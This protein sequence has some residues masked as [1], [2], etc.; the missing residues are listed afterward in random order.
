MNELGGYQELV[1]TRGWLGNG[2]FLLALV[3]T[4]LLERLQFQLRSAEAK[5]WWASN[6]RDVLNAFAFG[7]MA[8][9]LHGLGFTGPLALGLAATLVL[10]LSAVQ[11]SLAQ[12][13]LS[14]VLSVA[15]A[16]LLGLPVLIFPGRVHGL[17][18]GVLQSL[19]K[20]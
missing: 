18:R 1:S 19:F 17:F 11:T 14:T 8:L 16:F 20:L 6:G 10:V 5:A 9:G 2:A 3:L 7:V 15:T 4:A 12:H 13:R